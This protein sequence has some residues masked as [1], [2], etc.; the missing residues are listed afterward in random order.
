MKLFSLLAATFRML[1]N[2]VHESCG[3]VVA[4]SDVGKCSVRRVRVLLGIV[5]L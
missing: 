2:A 3:T 5:T 1:W 4:L